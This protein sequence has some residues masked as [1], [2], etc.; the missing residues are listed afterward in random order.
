MRGPPLTLSLLSLAAPMLLAAAPALD[1]GRILRNL[2]HELRGRRD[3]LRDRT[4]QRVYL[5]ETT[6]L[7]MELALLMG[8]HAA[9]T[10]Q[11]AV[12]ED[13]FLATPGLLSWRVERSR[14]PWCSNAAVDDLR[15][16]RTLLQAHERWGD[17]SDLELGL[18]IGR[19]V[20]LHNV[21]DGVLVDNAS[22]TCGARAPWPAQVTPPGPVLT[23]AFADLEALALLGRHLPEANGVLHHTRA[24]LLA[25]T[26]HPGGPQGRYLVD[27]RRYE[28]GSRN[29]IELELQR[30]HLLIWGADD[31][32]SEPSLEALCAQDSGW[33]SSDNIALIALSARRL[34]RCGEPGAS[35]QALERLP[36]FEL[37]EGPHAGLLGYRHSDNDTVVW[38]F[39]VLQALIA[40]EEAALLLD[41]EASGHR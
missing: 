7:A 13:R 34:R 6:T 17:P 31:P 33:R 40:S 16:V 12:L 5:S 20:L 38:S 30:L 15:A 25:G 36:G 4:D 37:D 14:E 29:A 2:D 3:T 41:G 35:T 39:D 28:G 10:E 1:A 19:A 23:L 32:M 9:F 21:R 11:R 8:D 26:L 18:R 22:W 27:E 24:V